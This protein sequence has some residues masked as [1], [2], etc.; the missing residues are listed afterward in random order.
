MFFFFEKRWLK[1][2]GLTMIENITTNDELMYNPKYFF[3]FLYFRMHPLWLLGW[4]FECLSFYNLNV[5]IVWGIHFQVWWCYTVLLLVL[6]LNDFIFILLFLHYNCL[7]VKNVIQSYGTVMAIIS[8][9][10]DT[11]TTKQYRPRDPRGPIIV[12]PRL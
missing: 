6:L 10:T 11:V 2:K 1:L 7:Y 4:T 12:F 9:Q 3:V 5:W 8:L